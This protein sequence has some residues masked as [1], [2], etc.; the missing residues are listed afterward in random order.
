MSETWLIL[1]ASSAMARALAR[2]VADEGAGVLLAGRDMADLEAQATD[3]GLRGAP[4]AEAVTF[5]ARDPAGFEAIKARAEATEGLLNIAVFVGSM[6]PQDE[7]DAD[8]ALIDGTV[9]DSFTGPARL[10]QMLAPVIEARCGGTVV[11]V[12]SVAGDRGRIG[13]YVYGGRQGGVSHLPIGIAQ[14]PDAF[15][16][17]C[18]D[19]KAGVRGH[20][21]DL[22]A[23]GDVPGGAPRKGGK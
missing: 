20:G 23:G 15:G 8:P 18:G 4:V 9:C 7:I 12:G 3:C 19:G 22:G 21:H 11:G 13:N 14:P 17:A 1:G 2:A 10:I 5:D 16:R 6:P